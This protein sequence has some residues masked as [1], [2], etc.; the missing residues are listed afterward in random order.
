VAA[1]IDALGDAA[2]VDLRVVWAPWHP[3]V[4]DDRARQA[5]PPQ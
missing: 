4:I 3:E 1:V 2:T 5:R